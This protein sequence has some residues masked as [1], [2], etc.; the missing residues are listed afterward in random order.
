MASKARTVSI[1]TI[2][3]GAR[4]AASASDGTAFSVL[5]YNLLADY[6]VGRAHSH[7]D[8]GNRLWSSR[9]EKAMRELTTAD[10][11][12]V[13]LQEVQHDVFDEQ[14]LPAMRGAGYEGI[15]Q[16]PRRVSKKHRHGVA[17]FWRA[18]RFDLI[19]CHHRSRSM[20]VVLQDGDAK[21]LEAAN[22]SE[23]GGRGRRLAVVNVHLEGD[24]SA[25]VKRVK[26]LQ[27]TLAELSGTCKSG[28]LPHLSSSS[29]EH[30][31]VVIC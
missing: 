4:L 9:F 10:A 13:S 1:P 12:V 2:A 29:V 14:L 11:D 31:A 26:Q 16:Q 22:A 23:E 21:I 20:T 7:I 24:P 5:S 19:Q 15:R 28:S 8:A 27:T 3:R 30:H 17:T 18:N 6:L 25:S